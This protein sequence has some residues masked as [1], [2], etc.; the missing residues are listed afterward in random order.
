MAGRAYIWTTMIYLYF[1]STTHEIEIT[2]QQSISSPKILTHLFCPQQSDT[3]VKLTVDADA[4][5]AQNTQVALTKPTPKAF[6]TSRNL[7]DNQ[8]IYLRP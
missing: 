5:S 7:A 2:C 6:W 8:A 3:Q 1:Y 4:V